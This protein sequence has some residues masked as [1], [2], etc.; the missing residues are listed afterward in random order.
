MSVQKLLITFL[1]V[2][3]SYNAHAAGDANVTIS[4][5]TTTNGSWSGSSTMTFTP[6]ADNAVVKI[7]EI[8]SYLTSSKNVIILTSCSGSGTQSGDVTISGAITASMVSSS[9]KTFTITAA[10]TITINSAINLSGA[11]GYTT[12]RPGGAISFS[13]SGSSVDINNTITTS[14]AA[15]SAAANLNGGAGG[16]VTISGT[17]VSMT[18][19]SGI[20]ARGGNG[21]GSGGAGGVVNITATSSTVNFTK[22]ITTTGGGTGTAVNGASGGNGGNVTIT[23]TSTATVANITARGGSNS[24]YY[25]CQ[26]SGGDVDITGSTTSHGTITVTKGSSAGGGASCGSKSDGTFVETALPVELLNFSAFEKDE[27]V[28]ITWETA[29][30]INNDYFI[31][32]KSSDGINWESIKTV[33]GAGDSFVPLTYSI[34][35]PYDCYGN[36]Y[37]KLKQIDF[38]GTQTTYKAI[39]LNGKNRNN[40]L[41]VNVYPNPTSDL[42]DISLLIQESESYTITL[43]NTLGEIVYKHDRNLVKGLNYMNISLTNYRKGSYYL[44]VYSDSQLL[45]T[46]PIIKL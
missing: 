33:Q 42:I 4:T 9:T 17:S 40:K 22:N 2:T 29:A 18:A 38:D 15:A 36:C 31:V 5:G 1:I 6:S 7:S 26:G 19:G 14:G 28:F 21:R 11:T 25:S 20:T 46:V 45:T 8:T 16:N 23:A 37:Y 24:H 10:G 32:E 34:I 44:Q 3:L 35:D 27:L 30:E 12:G 43:T 39:L 41:E 13:S